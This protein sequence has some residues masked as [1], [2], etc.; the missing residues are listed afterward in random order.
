LRSEELPAVA[1][2][3]GL[4]LD[5]RIMRAIAHVPRERF[6]PLEALE[7]SVQD[8]AIA[9]DGS[10][11]STVSALHAYACTFALLNVGEGDRV[12]DLGAGTGYGISLL[13]YSVG[14]E[15]HVVGVEI[16]A[17]LVRQGNEALESLGLASALRQ[18][19]ALDPTTW[20]FDASDM[21][22]VAVGFAL[23]ATPESWLAS[24]SPGTI[25][26]A[27]LWHDGALYLTRMV[28]C[29]TRFS[30]ERFDEVAYVRVRRASEV[31]GLEGRAGT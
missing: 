24:F 18:G 13:S 29:G 5:D 14:I 21:G 8:V 19:D 28:H 27:P 20:G 1:E 12:L 3:A 10:G 23:Q 22:K 7:D 31:G 26:V 25:I 15:G 4:A 11:L 9:L 17:K 16:D 30:H 6:V 2:L